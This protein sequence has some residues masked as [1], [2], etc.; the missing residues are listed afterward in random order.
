[1]TT[2]SVKNLSH[3][4]D[5]SRSCA[6]HNL[7]KSQPDSCLFNSF[8]SHASTPN[9]LTTRICHQDHNRLHDN[10]NRSN[11][12]HQPP[13]HYVTS[14]GHHHWH[15]STD[16]TRAP[17]YSK[18]ESLALRNGTHAKENEKLYI[19]MPEAEM[20]NATP[21]SSST[22]N[23]PSPGLRLEQKPVQKT[24]QETQKQHKEGLNDAEIESVAT[25]GVQVGRNELEKRRRAIQIAKGRRQ[26][27]QAFGNSN[28][29]KPRAR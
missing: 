27:R 13:R 4:R 19:R 6:G 23:P 5:S 16:D 9:K 11:Q 2:Q 25:A 18:Q 28:I 21:N 17:K 20:R 29:G 1:M 12:S 26:Q 22:T 3:F 10:P 24:P 7:H 14:L 15:H 8:L